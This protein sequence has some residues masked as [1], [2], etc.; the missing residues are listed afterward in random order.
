M[1]LD[2][3][4]DTS[5]GAGYYTEYDEDTK[6]W[7]VFNTENTKAFGCHASQNEAEYQCE[8]LNLFEIVAEDE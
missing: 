3:I 8:L 2:I 7:C 1:I 6:C 4:A 5:D